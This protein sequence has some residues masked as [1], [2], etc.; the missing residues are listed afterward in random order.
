MHITI[1][2]EVESDNMVLEVKKRQGN[3]QKKN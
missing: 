1:N 2:A 3:Y